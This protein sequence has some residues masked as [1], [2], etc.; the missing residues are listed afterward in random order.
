MSLA[1]QSGPSSIRALSNSADKFSNNPEQLC[2]VPSLAFSFP[3][4]NASK[5]ETYASLTREFFVDL[6]ESFVEAGNFNSGF[7]CTN[8]KNW[9]V[10]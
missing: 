8:L 6:Y 7:K 1:H 3:V 9:T 4:K 2:E 5:R 10:I